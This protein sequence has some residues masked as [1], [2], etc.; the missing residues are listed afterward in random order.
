MSDDA[1]PDDASTDEPVEKPAGRGAALRRRLPSVL[2]WSA[3]GLVV[4]GLAWIVVTG[5]LA[6][7][8]LDDAQSDIRDLRRAVMSGDLAK[9]DRLVSAI[10]SK[11]HSAYELTSGPAWWVG[12]NLP[13]V[14]TPMQTS[15][16]LARETDRLSRDALPVVV[17]LSKLVPRSTAATTSLDL[18][19]LAEIAPSLHRAAVASTEARAAMAGTSSSWLPVVSSAR[20]SVLN[21]VS[22]LDGELEGADRAVGLAVPMLGQHGVKRYFV[23]FM[24]EAEAR[25]GG[26]IPGAFAIVAANH[27]RITFEHFGTD[28]DLRGTAANIELPSDVRARYAG[29]DITGTFPNSNLSPDFGIAGRIWARTWERKTGER[30]D[31]AIAIDP[32]AIGYLLK[33]TGPARSDVVPGGIIAASSVVALTQQLQYKLY[34]LN[35]KP[36]KQAR[37]KFLVSVARSVS[38]KLTT[39][40]RPAGLVRALSKAASER[41]LLL[42]SADADLESSLRASGWGGTLGTADGAPYSGFVV[43]NAAGSKLDYY[44]QRRMTYRRDNCSAGGEAHATLRVTNGAPRK[45]LPPYVTIRADKP[46]RYSPGDNRMLVTYYADRTAE[47]RSVEVDGKSIP[48]V[49]Q[50]EGAT[51]TVTITLELA[52]GATR[53][54]AVAV[55]EPAADGPVEV[56]RQPGVRPIKVDLSGDRCR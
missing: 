56:L 44:L 47:V 20:R 11:T 46:G 33:V 17:R 1:A 53:T 48:F 52:A 32:T 39:F 7:S 35:T 23:G 26:G 10:S 30:V 18:D 42:W 16:V 38:E 29:S 40:G 8:R 45:G 6:R 4:V 9:A 31:G 36:E 28:N 14:G 25:G 37:K 5:L 49:V 24:N 19:A 3:L 22:R 50:Y 43:N 41:R 54:V 15:R 13:V 34:P 12:A 51:R 2:G 27:G 55:R 21:S